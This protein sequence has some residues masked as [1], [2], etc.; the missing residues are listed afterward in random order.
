MC[1]LLSREL[2][3][4]KLN[5]SAVDYRSQA[6]SLQHVHTTEQST[7]GLKDCSPTDSSASN[8]QISRPLVL[9]AVDNQA[10]GSALSHRTATI[11]FEEFSILQLASVHHSQM[12]R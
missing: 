8:V 5:P 12:D 7:T 6:V 10:N 1:V 3:K 9:A 4:S 2:F 11:L